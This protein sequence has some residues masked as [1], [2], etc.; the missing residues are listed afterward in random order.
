ML[1]RSFE[2]GPFTIHLYGVIIAIAILVGWHI[3]KIRASLY[4]IPRHLFDDSILL[5]PLV[6][7]VIG[8]RAYHVVDY[9]DFYIASPQSIINI[10]DGG[11]GIWGSLV[12][13]FVGFWL[14]AKIKSIDLLSLLDLISPS[15]IL[16]QAIGRI[17]NFVNQEGFGPP[18]NL[19]WG[20]FISPENRPPQFRFSTQFH[21]TFFYEAIADAIFFFILIY[22]SKR[23]KVQGSIFAMYLILYSLG[24]FIVEFWRI[25]TWTIGIIRVAHLLSLAAFLVGVWLFIHQRRGLDTT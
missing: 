5:L 11:L 16:G 20:I 8:A 3:A 24:R 7:A 12:G 21:P 4:K 2:I 22:L 6:L 18:T 10:P 23:L 9:W 17:G 14:V 13:I 25:D 1:P 15:L 19:P